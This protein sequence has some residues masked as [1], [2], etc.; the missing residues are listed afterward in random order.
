[1]NQLLFD[2]RSLVGIVSS[3]IRQ[4]ELHVNFNRI[5][6]ERMYRLADFSQYRLSGNSW[7]Q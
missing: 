2:G 7:L 5:D 4:N 3:I 6:W 1:M